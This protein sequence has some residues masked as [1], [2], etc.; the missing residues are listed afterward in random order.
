MQV[1]TLAAIEAASAVLGSIQL[2]DLTETHRDQFR[3]HL[4]KRIIAEFDA[5]AVM[6]WGAHANRDN[7]LD[8]IEYAVRVE[9]QKPG[10]VPFQ[11]SEDVRPL[12]RKAEGQVLTSS[13]QD[14]ATGLFAT[15]S[16]KARKQAASPSLSGETSPLDKKVYAGDPPPILGALLFAKIQVWHNQGP[17]KVAWVVGIQLARRS[18]PY[19]LEDYYLDLAVSP[20]RARETARRFAHT[21]ALDPEWADVYCDNTYSIDEGL[22]GLIGHKQG[23]GMGVGTGR[24]TKSVHAKFWGVMEM[25]NGTA[26]KRITLY[27]GEDIPLVIDKIRV[28]PPSRDSMKSGWWAEYD[29]L[30]ALAAERDAK[31]AEQR[32]AS[33]AARNARSPFTPIGKRF[34]A[35]YQRIADLERELA[36]RP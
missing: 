1:D 30:G 26:P 36:A 11:I 31:D 33:D 3:R 27:L 10:D 6:A 12:L 21:G 15:G 17:K 23:I 28:S 22:I 5:E 4:T 34:T 29:P 20:A 13:E 8:L 18:D 2:L 16:K 32:K 35:L 14:A 9:E 24:N 19:V 7:L 25:D